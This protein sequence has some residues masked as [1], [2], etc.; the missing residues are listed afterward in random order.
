MKPA[1]RRLFFGLF[2][3]VPD[4][5]EAVASEQHSGPV[6]PGFPYSKSLAENHENHIS[7]ADRYDMAHNVV[8]ISF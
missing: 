8:L 7:T 3:C 5:A 6:I 1:V 4:V 2:G